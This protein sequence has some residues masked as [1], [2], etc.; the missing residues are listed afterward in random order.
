MTG[1]VSDAAPRFVLRT[2]EGMLLGA[3]TSHHGPA[4]STNPVPVAV[5]PRCCRPPS[6]RIP[7]R[8][9]NC[10]GFRLLSYLPRAEF[11]GFFAVE[12][13]D[14]FGD[15]LDDVLHGFLCRAES[16]ARCERGADLI[17]LLERH[18][19]H[20]RNQEITA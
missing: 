15:L 20:Y 17:K 10:W 19:M 3:N 18:T 7:R 4:T 12:R 5:I 6:E 9:R 1:I 13:S 11:V 16:T 14:E 8:G 2:P